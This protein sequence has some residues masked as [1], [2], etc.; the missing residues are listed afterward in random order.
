[1][2]FIEKL[3]G[4]ENA[5]Q[6][7]PVGRSGADILPRESVF[8][9]SPARI[10]RTEADAKKDDALLEMS[11]V[12]AE[13][14]REPDTNWR[15]YKGDFEKAVAGMRDAFEP[16][17]GPKHSGEGVV[18]GPDDRAAV[19][20]LLHNYDDGVMGA[21]STDLT[22]QMNLDATAG[23]LGLRD[24]FGQRHVELKTHEVE[25]L[26]GLHKLYEEEKQYYRCDGM[27]ADTEALGNAL[28]RHERA[29]K[30]MKQSDRDYGDR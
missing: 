20:R 28:K 23:R 9:G 30:E 1:M 19:K 25:A 2:R 21:V 16:T 11:Q 4:R 18:L 29:N 6:A 10:V 3:L 26:K 17:I 22:W 12:V 24:P 8:S 15:R 27:D 13:I 14:E 7:E 5:V